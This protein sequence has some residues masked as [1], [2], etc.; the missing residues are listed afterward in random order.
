MSL[1]ATFYVTDSYEAVE[2]YK[3]AFDMTLG[4][5]L[6]YEDVEGLKAH[7][8]KI[9]DDY[10]PYKGYFHADLKN[11]NGLAFAVSGEL[12]SSKENAEKLK[13]LGFY[14]K[15][16]ELYIDLGSVEA[17]KRAFDVLS[18]GGRVQPEPKFNA[19]GDCV[20][21]VIDKFNIWWVLVAN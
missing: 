10:I 12:D 21:C 9:E 2:M 16:I 14:Q 20:A 11:D 5:H 8:L 13:S 18:E 7:G 19:I 1:G 17:V 4:Y 15:E 6:S 3:K